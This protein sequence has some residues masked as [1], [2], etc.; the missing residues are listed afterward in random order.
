[1]AKT[2][3]N[4]ESEV[5]ARYEIT[6]GE[7]EANEYLLQIDEARDY[8]DIDRTAKLY[9]GYLLRNIGRSKWLHVREG[10]K[11][12]VAW[13]FLLGHADA[14]TFEH[15]DPRVNYLYLKAQIESGQ[16]DQLT[17]NA[18]QEMKGSK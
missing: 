8:R 4:S 1:M 13:K 17:N 14:D 9:L 11:K 5:Y 16:W 15:D 2:L 12:F 10:I 18:L 3:I 6:L 7:A